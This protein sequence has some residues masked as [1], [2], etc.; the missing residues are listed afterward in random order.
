MRLL[1]DQNLSRHLAQRL[2]DTYPGATY[3]VHLGLEHADDLLLWATARRDGYI[4][5]TKDTDFQNGSRFAGPPPKVVHVALGNGPTVAVEGVLRSAR[6]SIL[7]V[8]NDERRLMV[9]K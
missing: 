9:L 5:V 7:E 2:A 8:G 4:S 6:A 3:V 1:F